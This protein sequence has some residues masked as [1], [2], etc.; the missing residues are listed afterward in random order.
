MINIA[1][2]SNEQNLSAYR[3]NLLNQLRP[4]LERLDV[5]KLDDKSTIEISEENGD[6]VLRLAIISTDVSIPPLFLIASNQQCNL[7]FAD[8]E[9]IECHNNPEGDRALVDMV[10]KLTERYLDGITVLEYYNRYE[11][12]VRKE[13]YFGIDTETDKKCGIGVSSYPLVFPKKVY[14]TRKRTFRFLE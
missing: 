1:S 6:W 11:K 13:C 10:V 3:L 2:L 8:G 4:T 9:Q 7:G 12:L 5:A 14:S